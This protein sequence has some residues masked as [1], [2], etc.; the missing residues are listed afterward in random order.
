MENNPRYLMSALL[1]LVIFS[2]LVFPSVHAIAWV[3]NDD[4][5]FDRCNN[6]HQTYVG[7]Q[8]SFGANMIWNPYTNGNGNQENLV[9]MQYNPDGYV[10]YWNQANSDWFQTLIYMGPAGC[11]DFSIEVWNT[12][13]ASWG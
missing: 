2:L 13:W 5:E 4:G 11:P 1:G 3:G 12:W 6:C 10:S 8:E 7:L 9:S